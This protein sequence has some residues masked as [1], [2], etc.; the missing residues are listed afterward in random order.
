[1]ADR[2]HG[3]NRRISLCTAVFRQREICL[4]QIADDAPLPV[5]DGGEHIYD[6]D[7]SGES[8]L[9]LGSRAEMPPSAA[10]Q[11]RI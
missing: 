4:R 9:L 2:I 5:P 8:C 10:A 6:P 1:M 11:L 3:R 7:V